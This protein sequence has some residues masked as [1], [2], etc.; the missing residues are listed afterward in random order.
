M[1]IQSLGAPINL[2]DNGAAF[3][4]ISGGINYEEKIL[5]E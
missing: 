4:I 1:I 5:K 2:P 3:Y